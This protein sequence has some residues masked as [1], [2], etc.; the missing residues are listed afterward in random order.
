MGHFCFRFVFLLLSLDVIENL[1]L[2]ITSDNVLCNNVALMLNDS[3]NNVIG[4]RWLRLSDTIIISSPKYLEV[5]LEITFNGDYY[6]CPHDIFQSLDWFAISEYLTVLLVKK[7]LV[8]RKIRHSVGVGIRVIN[9]FI[10]DYD[11]FYRYIFKTTW[12][13]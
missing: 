7:I 6:L 4:L 5:F 1:H 13:V 8:G 9:R 2:I 11:W 10:L 12:V 3:T